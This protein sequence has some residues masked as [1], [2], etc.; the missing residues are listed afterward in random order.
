MTRKFKS[1]RVQCWQAY[2]GV[3]MGDMATIL[4]DQPYNPDTDNDYSVGFKVSKEFRKMVE[5]LCPI[6]HKKYGWAGLVQSH[7][8]T[9]DDFVIL[10]SMCAN[11][12]YGLISR[13]GD[14]CTSGIGTLPKEWWSDESKK[15]VSCFLEL[16]DKYK[17]EYHKDN[18]CFY[19][20][21]YKKVHFVDI[22]VKPKLG[23]CITKE[24]YIE[25]YFFCKENVFWFN[26]SGEFE[27]F[28]KE[29]GMK[30]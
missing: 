14:F 13:I 22:V 9:E 26:P 11:S 8:I 17:I 30:I 2:G 23:W 15:E 25:D 27:A 20:P 19:L 28:V 7:I 16:L 12:A 10:P 4:T 18:N 5:D 3:K 1:T 24:E 21:H 29:K 6:Q